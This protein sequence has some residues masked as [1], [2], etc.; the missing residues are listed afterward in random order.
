MHACPVG[1]SRNSFPWIAWLYARSLD[2]SELDAGYGVICRLFQYQMRALA[3]RQDVLAKVQSV[4]VVPDLEGGGPGL[5]IRQ[6]GVAVKVRIRIDKHGLA[7]TQET[8]DIPLPDVTFLGIDV[9]REIEEIRYEG[10]RS[11]LP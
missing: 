8:V 2:L 9:N 10:A 4:D 7:K 1:P 6:V 5:V 11:R 3:R